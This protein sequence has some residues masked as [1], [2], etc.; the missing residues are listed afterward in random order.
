MFV[1][2]IPDLDDRPG[3]VRER[4]AASQRDWLG[5]L[6]TA[7]RIAIEEGQFRPEVDPMQLA[8]EFLCLAYG[9]HLL[10]RLLRDPQTQARYRVAQER[11]LD[12]VRTPKN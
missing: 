7:V 2:S 1:A 11:L 9:T 8:Q 6:A 10:M 5:T 3:P 12:S 4:L